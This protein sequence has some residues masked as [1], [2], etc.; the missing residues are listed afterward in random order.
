MNN[1]YFKGLSRRDYIQ[2]AYEI[3]VEEGIQAV[4]IRRIAKEMQ[5]STASLY[6]YFSSREELLYYSQLPTLRNYIRKVEKREGTWANKWEFYKGIWRCFTEEAFHNAQTYNLLFFGNKSP[7]QKYAIEEYYEMFPEDI[8]N[9]S[10]IFKLML[11]I[12]DFQ[13]RDMFILNK[14]TE[15][16]SLTEE[17]AKILNRMVCVL[18]EGYLKEILDGE[19]GEKAIDDAVDSYTEDIAHLVS[20][21]AK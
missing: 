10:G 2:K 7:S 6:R 9:T 3:I 17:N 16:D 5:C 1:N 8:E 21:L 13:S 14:Y 19:I 11:Q 15:T 18:F 20:W 12:T 4:S